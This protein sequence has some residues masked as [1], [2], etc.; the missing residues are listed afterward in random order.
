M[1]RA[2]S[3]SL[4]TW[5]ER[6]GRIEGYSWLLLLFIAMPLK[7]GFGEP[8]AVRVVG[9]AHGALFVSFVA[10]LA[11][12]FLKLGWPLRNT[13]ALFLTSLVPF[14]FLWAPRWLPPRE[15]GD[16]PRPAG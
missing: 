13:V 6:L 1:D 3:S 9:S 12:A 10:V 8:L 4:R 14:G 7:Y 11:A 2:P 15:D 16:G 5:V